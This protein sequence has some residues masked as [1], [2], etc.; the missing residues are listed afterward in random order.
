VAR[1]LTAAHRI[2]A[3]STGGA[4]MAGLSGCDARSEAITEVATDQT[5]ILLFF[6]RQSFL[7]PFK[8]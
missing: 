8:R 6:C 1:Y 5:G 4:V 3:F 7:T 2:G